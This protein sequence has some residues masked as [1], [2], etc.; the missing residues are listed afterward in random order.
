MRR[1]I[2]PISSFRTRTVVRGGSINKCFLTVIKPHQADIGRDANATYGP[3]YFDLDVA[4][5]RKFKLTERLNLQFRAQSINFTN[6]PHFRDPNGDFNSS[7]F[8]GSTGWQTPAAT[9]EWTLDN[10][11]SPPS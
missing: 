9:A 8:G 7:S 5:A 1:H 4:L 10:S 2:W 3:P 11:F 6:T